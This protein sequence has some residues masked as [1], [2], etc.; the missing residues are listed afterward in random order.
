MIEGVALPNGISAN[1][2]RVIMCLAG[3]GPCAGQEISVMM[4]LAPM[5][6]S[7]ALTDLNAKGW[8]EYVD[9]RPDRRRKPVQLSAAGWQ[10]YRELIP[11]VATVAESLLG[12]LD[13]RDCKALERLSRNIILN[14]E[15]WESGRTKGMAGW[16]LKA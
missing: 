13:A 6:V 2:L 16:L 1:M 15:D 10:A 7:R 8:V 3:E 4:G 12:S 14:I 5:G 9:S 11:H